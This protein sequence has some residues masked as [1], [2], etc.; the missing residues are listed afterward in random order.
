MKN[1]FRQILLLILVGT[2]SFA[3][4]QTEAERYEYAKSVLR[5]GLNTNDS[6]KIAE[7]YYL[8]AKREVGKMNY[9]EAYKNFRLSLKI[10]QK[11]NDY[12][13]IGRIY[14]R[15]SELEHQQG[16]FEGSKSY[17][18]LAIAIYKKNN[19]QKGIK[20]A[21]LMAGDL[22]LDARYSNL[23]I[24]NKKPRLD[25]AFYYYKK[26]EKIAIQEQNEKSLASARQV[27]GIIYNH[28]NDKKRAIEYLTLAVK[29]KQKEEPDSP[30][31]HFRMKLA[32]VYLQ[33]G[34]ID[35]AKKSLSETKKIIDENIG[36]FD[37]DALAAY[38]DVW[39]GYYIAIGDWQKAF[40]YREKH[41]SFQLKFNAAKEDKTGNISQWRVKLDTE[42]KEAELARK[43][44]ELKL[45]DENL[46]LQKRFIILVGVLLFIALVLC[47]FLYK[48]YKK[49]QQMSQRNA[50]LV[51]EQNHRVKNNFQVI[52]SM[53]NLQV[54]Y[55]NDKN[56]KSIFS[57]SQTRIDS[58]VLLHRQ[59][60]END[61]LEFIDIQGLLHEIAN[62]VALTFGVTD[63]TIK[64]NMEIQDLKIDL[65]TSIG[66][67]FNELLINSFKYSFKNKK[68]LIE[69]NSHKRGHWIEFIY[70]DF[71][72]KD[73]TDIFEQPSNTKSYG[74]NLIDMI[75]FQIN[76]T[77]KYSY[78]QG[79][80]FTISFINS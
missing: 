57:E 43:N 74:L 70:K 48:L 11:L 56:S 46:T 8:I 22:Y 14:L 18:N 65:A 59:L 72:A 51:Q 45:K 36:R 50:I 7:G 38:Y 71:G 28:L 30:L 42:R 39:K 44:L 66:L 31:I 67:I 20:D 6:I 55:L 53:L 68:P 3:Q 2:K 25:S 29:A 52:S 60:Y 78:Q 17:L 40:E 77:L 34:E 1:F 21:Y 10:N 79:S 47:F 27:L 62:L 23:G 49:N 80:I 37:E 4:A 35:K 19:I 15:L 33:C 13:K 61:E 64:S 5:E 26:I 16:F 73:L 24:P 32:D 75:L 76:G 12:Y 54:D 63:I 69:I 9:V 58:M 41:I